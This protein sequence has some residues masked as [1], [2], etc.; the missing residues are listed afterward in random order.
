[1]ADEIKPYVAPKRE[2]IS[3][4]FEPV[5]QPKPSLAEASEAGLESVEGLSATTHPGGKPRVFT[6]EITERNEYTGELMEPNFDYIEQLVRRRPGS[7]NPLPCEAP[8]TRHR[9]NATSFMKIPN[10]DTHM[11]VC[12]YH[13]EMYSHQAIHSPI[14][15]E[16]ERPVLGDMSGGENYQHYPIS[17]DHP[18]AYRI[19]QAKNAKKAEFRDE[20]TAS[21]MGASPWTVRKKETHGP[22]RPPVE[23]PEEDWFDVAK[24]GEQSTVDA[25]KIIEGAKRLR[26]KNSRVKLAHEALMHSM[27][28]GNGSPNKDAYTSK[29]RELG[30]SETE[31]RNLLPAAMKHHRRIT[32]GSS[33]IP[34]PKETKGGFQKAAEAYVEEMSETM[35]KE[36]LEG[37]RLSVG[38]FVPKHLRKHYDTLGVKSGAGWDEIN[39]AYRTLAKKYHPDKGGSVEDM[40]RI[41]TAHAALKSAHLH[42]GPTTPPL[43]A[44]EYMAANIGINPDEAASRSEDFASSAYLARM[45]G[46]MNPETPTGDVT[47]RRPSG[48]G[49]DTD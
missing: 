45:H 42:E 36:D 35:T 26:G 37:I 34:E 14:E 15:E 20:N 16:G 4:Q 13:R 7:S 43:N 19:M 48:A 40:V 41:N 31:T 38:S 2:D 12:S 30:L 28:V 39:S 11:P 9:G 8:G 17:A 47:K 10:R 21:Q 29:A 49:P 3:Q 46:M 6:P 27:Q 22:G 33:V 44:Y 25:A 1:M 24:V 5:Q 18:L 32:K 23:Q